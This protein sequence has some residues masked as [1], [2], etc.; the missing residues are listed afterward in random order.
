MA[1]AMAN[2]L[3]PDLLEAF[4]AGISPLGRIP[5]FTRRIL[6]EKDIPLDG[7]FSKGMKDSSLPAA[8]VVVNLTGIPGASLFPNVKVINW[9]VTDPY[10]DDIETYRRVRDDIDARLRDWIAELGATR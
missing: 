4:S 5:E 3:A 8:D 6:L 1:E 2:H 7:H 9:D 10:D